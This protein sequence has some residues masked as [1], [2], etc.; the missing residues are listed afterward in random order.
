M[1]YSV[2]VDVAVMKNAAYFQSGRTMSRGKKYEYFLRYFLVCA[3]L[4]LSLC[5]VNPA[6][7]N[8]QLAF[9]AGIK[10]SAAKDYATALHYFQK[11]KK[12]GLT[13]GALHYNLAVSYYKLGQYE[14]A[15]KIFN[16]L[17]DN[18]VFEQL[19]YF[20]L[21]LVANKQ[22]DEK[23]AIRWFQRASQHVANTKNSAK[24][25]KLSLVALKRLGAA[26]RPLRKTHTA[27]T[28]YVASSLT[29]D[30]NVT[31]VDDS[32]LNI[33]RKSDSATSVSAA[34]GRWLKGN[35]KQGVRLNLSASTR[36][37]NTLTQN[38]D[39]RLSM[40]V[41]RY[42]R[43]GS[44]RLRAGGGADEIYYNGSAYQRVINADVRGRK[45]LSKNKQLHLRYKLSRI[46]STSTQFDYLDGWRQQLRLGLQSRYKTVRTR[47][48]Y[49]LELNNRADSIRSGVTDRPF[50]SYS[51]TRHTLRASYWRKIANQWRLR[52]DARFRYS[53]Y[54]DANVR[55]VSGLS[56]Q[57]RRADSQTRLSLRVDRRFSRRWDVYLQYSVTSNDSSINSANE[58]RS[59]AR[60]LASAGVTWSF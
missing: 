20:N 50:T 29:Y 35:I 1:M 39:S 19:V 53:D 5:V 57:Q 18:P 24:I 45:M 32:L 37:Y 31:L 56:E 25:R 14:H 9:D 8:A 7:A 2:S 26:P 43:L 6:L 11:A 36:N 54:N 47:Y 52:L 3:F 59:Y 34:A 13:S 42:D 17:A 28:G 21:G 15:R 46:Q 40:S 12:T 16:Q 44:W 49:Q 23:A 51:P 48:Y 55:I 41:L 60:S 33:T 38:D 22:K 30:S 4:L 10:A 58:S 27:W